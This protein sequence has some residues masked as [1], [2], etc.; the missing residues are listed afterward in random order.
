[1]LFVH[2]FLLAIPGNITVGLVILWN[3]RFLSPSDIY[4]FHLIIADLLMALTLPFFSTSLIVGWVFGDAMC[5]LISLVKEANFYTSIL[6]LVCISVDRYMVIVRAMEARKVQRFMCTWIVCVVVWIVGIVLSLP[7]VYNNAHYI[8]GNDLQICAESYESD[9]ADEWRIANRLMRHL[10]GFLLPLC[11]MLTCYGLTVARL[12]RTRGFQRQRAMKVIAAVMVAFLL[13]WMPFNLATM[14]DTL[15]RAN[16][17]ENGCQ[18]QHAVS[19]AMFV[20]QSLAL[21]HCCINPL[22]YAFVGE[23]FRKR[24]FHMIKKTRPIERS[25]PSSYNDFHLS[26]PCPSS[27]DDINSI[28]VVI[29]YIVVSFFGLT[30]NTLVMFVVC[31]MK[32]HR[33]PTDIYLMHLAIA[34]LLFSLTLPIWAIYIKESNWVFGTF[35]CKLISGVQ[36]MAV[37]SGVFLLACISIDRYMA[38]VK[39]TQ[40]FS[41]QQNLVKIVCGFVWLGATLL[42]IPIMVQREAIEIN[43]YNM[44]HCYENITE[45]TEDWRLGLRV[46]R[47]VVGFFLP[48]MVMTVCYSCTI[49]TLSRARNSQ[50]H[51]AM[52]VILCVVLAFVICWLPNN[53]SELIDTLMRAGLIK[54][55]CETRDA[56]DLTM[57]ITQVLAFMH[58]AINPILYAFVGKKFR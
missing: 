5:K 41:K 36:E 49:G 48:L 3:L 8:K 26:I 51:K 16:L 43:G 20:T 25:T 33:R 35:M 4:L 13:C 6:F 52:R 10:L 2:I 45:N 38:I 18:A 55:T 24:F 28:G 32:S 7:A 19:L 42:S 9:I 22:L 53:V 14:V 37:Y 54:D 44:Q 40:F 56:L 21:L 58:C 39:A 23:K 11:I 46:V 30:G 17:M 12:L 15:L 1:I 34:D 31:T 29:S 50:K 27:L 47:H 57:Y